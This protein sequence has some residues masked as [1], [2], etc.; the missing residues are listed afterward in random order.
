MGRRPPLATR[1]PSCC[2]NS[3]RELRPHVGNEFAL[4]GLESALGLSSPLPEVSLKKGKFR[5][6]VADP[7]WKHR[8]PGWHGSARNHYP[9]LSTSAIAALDVPLLC[10]ESALLWL[11]ATEEQIRSG[12]ADFVARAWGFEPK[13]L[14][15]WVKVREKPVNIF[16]L[17]EHVQ[18]QKALVSLPSGLHPLAWPN[19]YYGRVQV[20]YCLV[21]IRGEPLKINGY[22]ERWK[23]VGR[24]YFAPVGAHSAKPT[25]FDELI[26]TLSPAPRLELFARRKKEHF[27]TW[28]NQ[29]EEPTVAVSSRYADIKARANC[30]LK[31][32]ATLKQL[33]TL[34]YAASGHTP[35]EQPTQGGVGLRGIKPQEVH[36]D[37]WTARRQLIRQ[38]DALVFAP[39]EEDRGP[40]PDVR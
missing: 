10:A 22:R 13:A 32:A 16:A 34:T 4:G 15:T 9:T 24:T 40:T 14:F 26:R 25:L 20:E 36:Q 37:S 6:V 38:L 29:A 33:G 18:R 23:V 7:P 17:S 21:G 31:L 3:S 35:P 11:W 12:E 30:Y 28:G 5:T 1:R 19:G 39:E 8:S 2:Q 27:T